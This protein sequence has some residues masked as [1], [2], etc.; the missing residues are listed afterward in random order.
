MFNIVQTESRIR[1]FGGSFADTLN[2]GRKAGRSLPEPGR[3]SRI[4]GR[5]VRTPQGSVPD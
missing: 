3:K 5:K 4:R 1:A 2:P